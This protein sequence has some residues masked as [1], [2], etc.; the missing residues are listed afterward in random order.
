MLGYAAFVEV[1]DWMFVAAPWP[2]VIETGPQPAHIAS[3]KKEAMVGGVFLIVLLL[4]C[5]LA[6]M[7]ARSV[8]GVIV[9]VFLLVPRRAQNGSLQ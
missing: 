7:M 4:S 6:I 9:H 1:F 2:P 8:I 3:R 5:L